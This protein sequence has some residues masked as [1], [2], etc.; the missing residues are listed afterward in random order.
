LSLKPLSQ[1]ILVSLRKIFTKLDSVIGTA[2]LKL[3][4]FIKFERLPH[5]LKEQSK[6]KVNPSKGE[7]PRPFRQKLQKRGVPK[8]ILK[9]QGQFRI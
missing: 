8:E 6:I 4:S 9:T 7:H 2:K 5:T 3:S 1:K